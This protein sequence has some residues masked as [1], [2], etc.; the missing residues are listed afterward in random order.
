MTALGL[1]IWCLGAGILADRLFS[2]WT[3]LGPNW[4]NKRKWFELAL[5]LIGSTLII[6]GTVLQIGEL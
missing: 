3:T 6:I 5:I 4:S 1:F 2:F